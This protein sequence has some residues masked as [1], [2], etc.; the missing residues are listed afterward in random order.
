[1][2]HCDGTTPRALNRKV[3]GARVPEVDWA[4]PM[5]KLYCLPQARTLSSVMP[6]PFLTIRVDW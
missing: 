6:E 5:P 2:K 3:M 4:S 1:M